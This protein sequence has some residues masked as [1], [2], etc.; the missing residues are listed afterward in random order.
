MNISYFDN[1]EKDSILYEEL[2][3]NFNDESNDA[4]G[5]ISKQDLYLYF[6]LIYGQKYFSNNK[7]LLKLLKKDEFFKQDVNSN[8]TFN[9]KKRYFIA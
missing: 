5:Y 9:S 7:D 3:Y 6:N 1:V 2:I 8:K 4:S